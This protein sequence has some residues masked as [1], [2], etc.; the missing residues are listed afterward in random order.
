MN[1][2]VISMNKNRGPA[3]VKQLP[4]DFEIVL[5]SGESAEV[6]GHLGLTPSFIVISGEDGTIE[7][8]TPM[9]TLK[10]VRALPREVPLVD[11]TAEPFDA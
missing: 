6:T 2:N 10:Y 9:A 8:I 4:K 3:E 1:D 5:L 7:Y 11:S